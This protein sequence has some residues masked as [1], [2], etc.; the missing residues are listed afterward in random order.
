MFLAHGHWGCVLF[1]PWLET[2]LAVK[3]GSNRVSPKCI[4]SHLGSQ[5]KFFSLFPVLSPALCKLL[6]ACAPL[7]REDPCS[8][9][10]V[11][12]CRSARRFFR[13][14]LPLNINL[15]CNSNRHPTSWEVLQEVGPRRGDGPPGERGGVA[16]PKP[17]YAFS[18]GTERSEA[19]VS[20]LVPQFCERRT[21][22][23]HPPQPPWLTPPGPAEDRS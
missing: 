11:R 12:I 21:L 5:S 20:G 23:N 2:V 17:C 16:G 3:K 15:A 13:T 22:P 6:V 1:P 18:G 8:N 4:M 19:F 7:H 9:S 14:I 10:S